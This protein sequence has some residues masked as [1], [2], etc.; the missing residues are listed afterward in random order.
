M[1]I[2]EYIR[3]VQS[4]LGLESDGIA[5]VKTWEAIVDRLAPLEVVNSPTTQSDQLSG[6]VDER[7]EKNIG[8]L[9]PEVRPYARALIHAAAAQGIEIKVISGTR[10]YAE[11][12]ALYAKGRT[13]PGSRVTNAQGGFS[14][15]NFGIAFDIGVFDGT[16]YVP[17]SPKYKAVGSIGKSLGL[18]W[19][20]DWTTI[21][22]EPHFQLKPKWAKS[23][24]ESAMLAK[25]RER[26]ESGTAAFA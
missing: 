23:L 24:S 13:A 12:D 25:L 17:E 22:D 18:D 15:H 9:L 16:R 1:N 19:G 8:T 4:K 7:S 20:G 14:N 2:S 6:M 5:G 3:R 21:V 11:Q 26:K 10:T